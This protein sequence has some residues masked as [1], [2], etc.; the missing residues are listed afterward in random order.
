MENFTITDDDFA[1]LE[2]SR[3]IRTLLKHAERLDEKITD[4]DP[5]IEEI[6]RQGWREDLQE[7]R[8]RAFKLKQKLGE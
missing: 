2:T 1:R 3:L 6:E 7:T 5:Y 8:D 4:P